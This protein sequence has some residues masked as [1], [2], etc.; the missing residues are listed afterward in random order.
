VGPREIGVAW[1]G[2]ACR[3]VPRRATACN[4]EAWW[5]GYLRVLSL[6]VATESKFEFVVQVR[7]SPA[8]Q[9][10]STLHNSTVVVM[11]YPC[12]TFAAKKHSYSLNSQIT[13]RFT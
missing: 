12:C 4:M 2:K 5:R 1:R 7:P 6:V 9:H 11:R 3:G 13:A 10:L 8:S